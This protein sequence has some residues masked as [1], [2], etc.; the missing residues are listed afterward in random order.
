MDLLAGNAV[1]LRVVVSGT[2]QQSRGQLVLEVHFSVVE[3]GATRSGLES[4]SDQTGLAE[5]LE[6]RVAIRCADSC[7]AERVSTTSRNDLLRL[8]RCEARVHLRAGH[9]RTCPACRGG[10]AEER[11]VRVL[12]VQVTRAQRQRTL[13]IANTSREN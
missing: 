2:Q 10:V 6:L 13:C 12:D 9:V 4:A 8:G 1:A 7:R 11:E 3:L 5:I